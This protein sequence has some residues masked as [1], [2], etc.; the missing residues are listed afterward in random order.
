MLVGSVPAALAP[1]STP[2]NRRNGRMVQSASPST[3]NRFQLRLR[4]RA[5]PAKLPRAV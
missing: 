5:V 4:R 3:D 2:A 1:A